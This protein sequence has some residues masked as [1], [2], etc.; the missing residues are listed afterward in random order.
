[1]AKVVLSLTWTVGYIVSGSFHRLM[2]WF[3][4]VHV[5]VEGYSTPCLGSARTGGFRGSPHNSENPEK[6]D[7]KN[8]KLYYGRW[9]KILN[10][11]SLTLRPSQT[12]KTK[13]RLLLKKHSEQGHPCCF[14]DNHFVNSS[15]DSQH[16]I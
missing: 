9:S 10:T 16:F 1:M 2:K 8:I 13:I 4:F 6:K 3:I 5:T 7:V 15:P 14:L 12:V 11:N